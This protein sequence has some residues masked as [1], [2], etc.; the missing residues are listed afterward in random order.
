MKSFLKPSK[1]ES[2][3]VREKVYMHRAQLRVIE[4]I[5]NSRKKPKGVVF[6]EAIQ[7]YIGFYREGEI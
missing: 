6:L 7:L 2:G 5:S 3:I 4:E 1:R